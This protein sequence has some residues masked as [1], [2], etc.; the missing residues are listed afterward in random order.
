MMA[1]RF[2]TKAHDC[3]LANGQKR[4]SLAAEY[5]VHLGELEKIILLSAVIPIPEECSL[6][7]IWL[8]LHFGENSVEGTAPRTTVISKNLTGTGCTKAAAGKEKKQASKIN[9]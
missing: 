5:C 7:C 9:I 4:Q 3:R 6:F 8:M 2:G 1:K